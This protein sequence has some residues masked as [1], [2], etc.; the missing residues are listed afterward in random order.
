MKHISQYQAGVL[1]HL[2]RA[3]GS[4]IVHVEVR[5]DDRCGV[6]SQGDCDCQPTVESGARI[7]RKYGS[8]RVER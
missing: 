2:R 1:E 6:F 5:H 8:R 3:D 4:G 7:E